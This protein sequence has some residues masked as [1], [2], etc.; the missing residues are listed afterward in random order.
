MLSEVFPSE[1][2]FGTSH[3]PASVLPAYGRQMTKTPSYVCVPAT[4]V[5]AVV[6]RG[7]SATGLVARLRQCA[8]SVSNGE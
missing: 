2:T 8:H 7:V 3:A 5:H 4:S 6:S 1:N